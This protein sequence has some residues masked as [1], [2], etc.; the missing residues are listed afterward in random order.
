MIK[1]VIFDFDG[2]LV[3]S[4][5]IK[6]NAFARLFEAEGKD[7]VKQIVDYHLM[8]AG[9]SRF[10]KFRYFYKALL[11][12][13]LTE[14]KFKELCERFSDLVME[15]V[16][17]APYVK[18]GKEFLDTYSAAYKCFIATATPQKEI[19]D[20]VKKRRME[21]YFAGVYGA[22]KTKSDAVSEIIRCNQLL[23]S[24]IAYIG[25]AMSDYEAAVTNGIHFMARINNNEPIFKGVDC[26]KIKDLNG[27]KEILDRMGS[28]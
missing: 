3:E 7:I 4:V 28:L 18:G 14:Q 20:I 23:P 16:I 1:A 5:D 6:T 27:L 22:P 10:E 19:D 24:E 21:R 13:E 25:D 15:E 11:N 2:V 8:H 12:R 26:I 17:A 9:V